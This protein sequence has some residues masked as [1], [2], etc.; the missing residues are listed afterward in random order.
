MANPYGAPGVTVQEVARKREAGEDFVLLDIREPYELEIA[1]LGD[2]VEL[3][4]MSELVS[5]HTE[6][7]PAAAQD[8][9][10]EIIV[11]CRSGN[12]SAQVTMW[13]RQQGWS[14]VYNLDGGINAWAQ[15]IDPSLDFY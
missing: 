10:A 13:L 9:D 11:M 3:A 15:Q 5:R 4:P 6:A 12:R 14:N 2:W 1:N 7:L 8:K